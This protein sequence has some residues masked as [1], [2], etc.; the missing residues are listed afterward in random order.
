MRSVPFIK[1]IKEVVTA[2]DPEIV[3][4]HANLFKKSPVYDTA[5]EA[6]VDL[7]FK[8]VLWESLLTEHWQLFPTWEDAQP[9]V[10]DIKANIP[11]IKKAWLVNPN[12][13]LL[14]V[15]CAVGALSPKQLK[16]S[17][18]LLMQPYDTTWMSENA[19]DLL[20]VI[21]AP[22]QKK[23]VIRTDVTKIGRKRKKPVYMYLKDQS[24]IQ[25]EYSI[26]ARINP[27]TN[28]ISA[29]INLLKTY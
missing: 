15:L 1:R 3:A 4:I 5:N 16:S 6:Y 13:S 25:T 29:I 19:K 11:A 20:E 14:S 18:R 28:N 17:R 12:L 7:F 9:I 8:E 22:A 2:T 21:H 24:S 23:V 26:K 27:P 10:L